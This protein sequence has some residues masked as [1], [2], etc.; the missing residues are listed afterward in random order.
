MENKH[1]IIPLLILLPYLLYSQPKDSASL[2]L[3]SSYTSDFGRNFSGGIKP[4][5]FYLGMINLELDVPLF[6][7]SELFIQLQN[8]HGEPMGS[9]YA[10]DM[11]VFS[12]I[13]N[14]NYTYL[15]SLWYKQLIGKFS[16]IIGMHDLNSEFY[17]TEL[18]A[19]FLNSSF[20]IQPSA[21]WNMPVSI[22]PKNAP[23]LVLKYNLSEK[24]NHH[25]CLV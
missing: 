5:N 25:F 14:G 7:N 8:T 21:S 10:G 20:G 18:G 2:Q 17:I 11:Q 16:F 15:Y 1:K 19:L 24:T 23:G 6:K 12:N 22:F 3:G 13:E 9:K 4:G